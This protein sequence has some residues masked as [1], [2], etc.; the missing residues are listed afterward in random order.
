MGET[1][2]GFEAFGRWL[3]RMGKKEIPA[4]SEQACRKAFIQLGDGVI[5]GT[6]VGDPSYWQ[7]PPPAGYT[8]G[9]ARGGWQA[10]LNAPA[11][12]DPDRIDKSG[13][14]PRQ[15]GPPVA[16]R[17]RMGDVAYWTNNTPYILRLVHGW[18]RQAPDGWV[19][20]VVRQVGNQFR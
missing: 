15:E 8:G 20:R 4:W 7:S 1:R 2:G 10:T 17:F 9:R 11:T 16:A 6:P 14:V 5:L 3:D 19:P 13:T 18:S 12:S